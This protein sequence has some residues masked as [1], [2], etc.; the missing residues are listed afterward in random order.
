VGPHASLGQRVAGKPGRG[1]GKTEREKLVSEKVYRRNNPERACVS[2]RVLEEV[3]ARDVATAG[4]PLDRYPALG[5][6]A[7]AKNR[8]APEKREVELELR[9][10]R[11]GRSALEI[12]RLSHDVGTCKNLPWGS[13]EAGSDP[14]PAAANTDDRSYE[15]SSH[16]TPTSSM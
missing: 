9:G 10:R 3:E 14:Y 5:A 16:I 13:E 6:H 1:G 2:R 12:E 7:S 15:R 8:A 4:F 11:L